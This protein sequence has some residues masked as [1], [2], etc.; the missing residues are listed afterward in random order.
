MKQGKKKE[1]QKQK[2]SVY[3]SS[4]LPWWSLSFN[5]QVSQKKTTP[6]FFF[7][8]G[9]TSL[10]KETNL[11]FSCIFNFNLASLQYLITLIVLQSKP[12][13]IL[14]IPLPSIWKKI[15]N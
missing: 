15:H 13:T 4:L 14:Y 1:N 5:S 2:V 9:Q 12:K 3:H 7:L 11:F 6:I 8:T 10:A